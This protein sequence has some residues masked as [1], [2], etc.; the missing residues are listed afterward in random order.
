MIRF[1]SIIIVTIILLLV[2]VKHTVD[3]AC[4][5]CEFVEG[6]PKPY[7]IYNIETNQTCLEASLTAWFLDESHV[8]CSEIRNQARYNCGCE[9]SSPSMVPTSNPTKSPTKV[10]T[11]SPTNVP[12][13]EPT[14]TPTTKPSTSPT[15][16]PT[17]SPTSIPTTDPT[18]SPTSLPTTSPTS[19]P[20]D[21][22][23]PTTFPTSLPT[24]PTP[25]PSS[26]IDK[27]PDCN[28]LENGIYPNIPSNLVSTINFD[29]TAEIF[30]DVGVSFDTNDIQ[31][32]LQSS[33]SSIISATIVGCD[34]NDDDDVGDDLFIVGGDG[35]R[36]H[37]RTLIEKVGKQLFLRRKLDETTT[38]EVN[39]DD[40]EY[41]VHYVTF[42]YLKENKVQQCDRQVSFTGSTCHIIQGNIELI[43]SSE[44]DDEESVV[45]NALSKM[46]DILKSKTTDIA[47]DVDGVEDIKVLSV[48]PVNSSVASSNNALP[49]GIGVGLSVAALLAG[50]LFVKR[51]KDGVNKRYNSRSAHIQYLDENDKLDYDEDGSSP[52]LS[53][54]D[55]RKSAYYNGNN[56]NDHEVTFPLAS[57]SAA[58]EDDE[59][60]NLSY[61]NDTAFDEGFEVELLST[62]NRFK[63][64]INESS[65]YNCDDT[66]N[67]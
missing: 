27:E 41:T 29:Y 20:T 57:F 39:N 52:I 18:T 28:A 59:D 43:Y 6:I 49:I 2:S 67:L 1:H 24:A 11:I 65:S 63:R 44:D 32:N 61:G 15:F 37:Q 26:I 5:I 42:T 8:R 14:P 31:S 58:N 45:L 13:S 16:L 38:E 19:L 51:R 53:K 30:I 23:S 9:T 17:I 55:K 46:M 50:G 60:D 35:R 64:Q 12:T 47:S 62:A 54:S 10:P 34:S 22:T 66:V 3:A 56:N 7:A 4:P 48:E 33:A 40:D 36:R 25:S 21:T